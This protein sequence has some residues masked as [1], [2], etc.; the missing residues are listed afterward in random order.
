MKLYF[1]GDI[2]SYNLATKIIMENI[3]KNI[4]DNDKIIIL[5]DNFYPNGVTS[6]EDER[7]KEFE[8]LNIP[9]ETYSILGNHDYLGNIE[10]QIN[11]K[12][13]NMENNYYKKS[14]DSFDLFFI[15]TSVILPEYSNLNYNIVKSKLKKEPLEYSSIML[16]WLD[17]EL[18]KSDKKKIVIGHY[19]IVSYGMYGLNKMLFEKLFKIFKKNSVDYYVSGH[20]H[21]LQL[22]NI[23]SQDYSFKQIISGSG[24]Y[25]YP[26]NKNLNKTS[27]F[28]NGYVEFNLDKNIVILKD[29][30]NKT[31]YFEKIL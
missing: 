6:L 17:D 31:L 13:W 2:G 16:K 29:F 15:D 11:Y 28:S 9:V 7:F 22:I 24:S 1:I 3:K 23:T 10:A 21:N 30:K 5:G 25:C 14:F 26:V 20:D 12:K 8:D 18:N 4:S 27:Y 19:P